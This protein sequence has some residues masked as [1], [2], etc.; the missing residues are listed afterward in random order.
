MR[1]DT[2][3][4]PGTWSAVTNSPLVNVKTVKMIRAISLLD[5]QSDDRLTAHRSVL[6]QVA[7]PTR[8]G[9]PLAL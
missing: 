3:T 7:V 5:P 6:W 1:N 4:A 2:P 8:H 9:V